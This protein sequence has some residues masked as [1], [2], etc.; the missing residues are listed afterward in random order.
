MKEIGAEPQTALDGAADLD[1]VIIDELLQ[2]YRMQK[3]FGFRGSC[4]QVMLTSRPD[5]V[6]EFND[7]VL[8]T[9]E[10]SKYNKE[11][12]GAFLLPME[13]ARAVSI[14]VLTS[15]LTRMIKMIPGK[16][17]SF[18]INLESPW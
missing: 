10:K 18:M 16:P 8:K 5:R 15:I 2:S 3:R 12:V 1:K 7:I 14:S 17:V 13:R 4:Q 6:G 11:D 9:A